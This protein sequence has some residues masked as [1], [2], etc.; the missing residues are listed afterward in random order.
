[1][2]SKSNINYVYVRTNEECQK[3]NVV[4]VGFT[5][6]GKDLVLRDFCEVV[7]GKFIFIFHYL[8]NK[9]PGVKGLI[10]K[11]LSEYHSHGK[12]YKDTVVGQL[13]VMFKTI[14][15]VMGYDASAYRIY[16]TDAEIE[17]I[18]NALKTA[19]I[20]VDD[21]EEKEEEVSDIFAEDLSMIVGDIPDFPK[22]LYG[23][24]PAIPLIDS[25]P[26]RTVVELLTP[27]ETAPVETAPVDIAPVDTAP[28]ATAPVETAVDVPVP[29]PVETTAVETAPMETAVPVA[30]VAPVAPV[31]DGVLKAID[32]LETFK[33]KPKSGLPPLAPPKKI[34]P[35][36]STRPSRVPNRCH[37]CN[38]VETTMWR[39]IGEGPEVLCDNCYETS[40]AEVV[41]QQKLLKKFGSP[42]IAEVAEVEKFKQE[43]GLGIDVKTEPALRPATEGKVVEQVNLVTDD[44]EEEEE[45]E[46]DF[47]KRLRRSSRQSSRHNSD[48]ED[49]DEPKRK[50]KVSK[51]QPPMKKAKLTREEMK[52]APVKK[53]MARAK[54]MVVQPDL[55]RGG[56]IVEDDGPDYDRGEHKYD[57]P[58][59]EDS[60]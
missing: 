7:K 14:V 49:D 26:M 9:F 52:T 37:S 31:D 45:E 48:R 38:C 17:D 12:F 23:S 35:A 20:K 22:A 34:V 5:R 57:S 24:A 4:M 33:I 1:M 6:S 47:R 15:I 3:H 32:Q 60:E 11:V 36:I 42:S 44:E 13:D 39:R 28:V 51:K 54:V 46:E 58:V 2:A 16:K 29:V 8:A 19:I 53:S 30:P 25:P 10:E 41:L 40:T 59:G 56:F 27:V 18:R 50:A 21:N 55:G 43:I